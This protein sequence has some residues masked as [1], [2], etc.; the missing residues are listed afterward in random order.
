MAVFSSNYIRIYIWSI[1]V[2]S[3]KTHDSTLLFVINHGLE[4]FFVEI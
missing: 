3:S 1:I 2:P 4:T